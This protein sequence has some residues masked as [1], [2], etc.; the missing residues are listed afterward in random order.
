MIVVA[1]LP[2]QP[3]KAAHP[4]YRRHSATNLIHPILPIHP[5]LLIHPIHPMRRS[6][7]GRV[8]AA[9]LARRDMGNGNP[10]LVGRMRK[11]RQQ[12]VSRLHSA[13]Y[14]GLLIASE[15]A[16]WQFFAGGRRSA[17]TLTSR[18]SVSPAYYT[19]SVTALAPRWIAPPPSAERAARASLRESRQIVLAAVHRHLPLDGDSAPMNAETATAWVCHM[20]APTM[21]R[22]PTPGTRCWVP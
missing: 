12:R 13:A 1:S 21:S 16:S 15:P 9:R 4:T 17:L 19:T 2:V 7:V 3:V 6:A 14:P 11:V 8:H 5:I 22:V 10:P 18:C 20:I